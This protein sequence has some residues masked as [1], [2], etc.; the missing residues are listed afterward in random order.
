M[1]LGA[2]L[3]EKGRGSANLGAG[4]HEPEVPW[5]DMPTA[6]VKAVLR[7]HCQ[8]GAVACEALLDASPHFL[9]HRVHRLS[10]SR[11]V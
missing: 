11:I 2:K 3:H 5:L 9:I 7:G 4:E 8:T 10:P 1:K 6:Y